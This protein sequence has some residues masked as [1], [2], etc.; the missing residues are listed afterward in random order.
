MYFLFMNKKT[1]TTKVNAVSG[2]E[3]YVEDQPLCLILL[4]ISY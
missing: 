2:F 1:D 4:I 3:R